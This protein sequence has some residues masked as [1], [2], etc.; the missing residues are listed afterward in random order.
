MSNFRGN[1][2]VFGRKTLIDENLTKYGMING[3]T[4]SIREFISIHG[5]DVLLDQ[6]AILELYGFESQQNDKILL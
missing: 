1:T 3:E 5:T 6:K 4:W 2:E